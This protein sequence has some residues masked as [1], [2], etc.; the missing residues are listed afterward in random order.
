MATFSETRAPTSRKNVAEQ[1]I[2]MPNWSRTCQ[3]FWSHSSIFALEKQPK[4]LNFQNFFTSRRSFR[5][6]L[7]WN[8]CSYFEKICSWT[9]YSNAKLV[10]N[11]SNFLITLFC[12]CFRKTNL[13]SK[14]SEFLT[15]RDPF[16]ASFNKTRAPTS[17]KYVAQ[18][19]KVMPNW[20][21]TFQT[22][23]LHSSV[24]ALEE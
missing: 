9:R 12:F 6:S 21:E 19:G 8:V 5:G 11:I 20:S 22:F 18:Q 7:H 23:W 15:S 2:L 16:V 14:I 17:R 4:N 1:G 24:F 10:K 3:S 13:K